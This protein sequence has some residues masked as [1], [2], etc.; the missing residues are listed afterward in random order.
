MFRPKELFIGLRYTRAKRRN[1]FVS[2]ISLTS[3]LGVTVG[4]AALI[5]V[6]SVMN[7]FEQEMRNRILGMTAHATVSDITGTLS[8]WESLSEKLRGHDR[9]V[10]MAPY[11]SNEAMLNNGRR[12]S[13]AVVRGV[14]PSEENKVSKVGTSMVSGTINELKP[15]RYGIIL[16]SALANVLGTY[17]GDKVTL[18]TPQANFT[19]IGAVPRLRRFTVVGIFEVG[20]QEFDRNTAIIHMQDAQKVFSFKDSISGLRLKLDDLFEAPTISA[21]LTQQLGDDY[22]VSDWTKR[23]VNFFRALKMEKT[24]MFIIL[25]MIV[26]VAAFNIVSSLVMT[27]TDKQSDIAILRTI[28]M[29]PKSI[30]AVFM[31]QGTI[32]GFLGVVLGLLIGVPVALNIETLIPSIEAYFQTDFLPCDVYYICDLPSD[33]HTGDTIGISLIAMALSFLA[34]IYPAWRASRVQPIDALRFE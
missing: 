12:V 8:D 10:G 18:I 29:T 14:L 25:F 1:H 6:L 28:G 27:V 21:Q 13:G 4:V 20:M 16:G 23:H 15:G 5:I 3:I 32:I 9:I 31:I 2:F 22:W 17:E 19:P 30:M 24:V 7:G 34:T 33:L 11:V 26:A